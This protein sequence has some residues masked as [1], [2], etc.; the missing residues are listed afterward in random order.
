MCR[1]E[2]WSSVRTVRVLRACCVLVAVFLI[3][4]LPFFTV[5]IINAVCIRQDVCQSSHTP[6]SNESTVDADTETQTE[7]ETRCST[8]LCRIDP[9]VL[10]VFVWL[11]YTASAVRCDRPTKQQPTRPRR[12]RLQPTRPQPTRPQPT[13]P[14]LTGPQRTTTIEHRGNMAS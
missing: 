5:N 8:S 11:G 12:T 13:R 6:S 1:C 10:S 14:R 2:C 9:L 4:W 3:C 7:T